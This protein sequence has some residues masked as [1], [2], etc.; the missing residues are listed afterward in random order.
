MKHCSKL[1]K[2]IISK[3][4]EWREKKGR[5]EEER[6]LEIMMRWNEKKSKKHYNH[7][8]IFNN[9]GGCFLCSE[10]GRMTWATNPAV[11]H[12]RT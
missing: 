6:D 10:S 4:L 1:E 5:E 8:I 9:K 2:K 3:E 11:M 7:T 12:P